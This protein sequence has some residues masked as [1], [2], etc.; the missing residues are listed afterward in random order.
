[1]VVS[2]YAEND[3]IYGAP[4]IAMVIH[5]SVPKVSRAMHVLGLKS[6]VAERFVCKKSSLT[7]DEKHI[8]VN[9]IKGLKLT[10]INQVW[11]TDITFIK[12]KKDG[13]FY[14]ITFLDLFSKKVVAWGLER[15]QR[16]IEVLGVLRKA[17]EARNPRP[18]LIIHSD[19]GGQMRSNDYRDYLES[20]HFVASYTSLNHSCDENAGQESFHASLKKEYLYQNKPNNFEE[21]FDTIY[22]YIEL[23]YNPKRIH[24]AIN[25]LSPDDFEASLL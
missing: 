14:L 7:E 13:T 3:G 19:K 23:F 4:K 2:T 12:T 22:R 18:G 6:I 10:G 24:S 9:L 15:R 11:T 8:I 17:V 1:L 16:S 21:A 20:H 5:C 25:Y